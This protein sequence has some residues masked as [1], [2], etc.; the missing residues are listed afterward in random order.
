MRI[1]L[2]EMNRE[3][4][5][6]RLQLNEKDRFLQELQTRM[7]SL[8]EK[9][10]VSEQQDTSKSVVQPPQLTKLE[11]DLIYEVLRLIVEEASSDAHL[12][13]DDLSSFGQGHSNDL[14]NG[15]PR[16]ERSLVLT[17]AHTALKVVQQALRRR[18]RQVVDVKGR[19]KAAQE[20]LSVEKRRSDER[21]SEEKSR[22]QM[23]DC[24]HDEVRQLYAPPY[25][26]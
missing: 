1:R 8:E 18:Q 4:E 2:I 7:T 6:L 13:D 17:F 14:R 25:A 16:D 22:Q 12:C 19:L 21:K 23:T 3:N 9:S 26:L 10:A 20:E 24:L 15:G 11:S 5:K